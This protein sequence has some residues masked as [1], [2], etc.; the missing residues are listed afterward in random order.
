MK[1]LISCKLNTLSAGPLCLLL[2]SELNPLGKVESLTSLIQIQKYY[3]EKM[4]PKILDKAAPALELLQ[5][6][7]AN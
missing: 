6:C 5:K 2:T 3:I 1:G 7:P 4:Y